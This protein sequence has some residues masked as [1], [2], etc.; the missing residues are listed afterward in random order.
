MH[1]GH[2]Y[3]LGMHGGMEGAWGAS[4]GPASTYMSI[5][6]A[7]EYKIVVMHACI[8]CSDD[9]IHLGVGVRQWRQEW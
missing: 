9:W 3:K 7:Q 5:G 1:N 4:H 6:F 2:E 8:S